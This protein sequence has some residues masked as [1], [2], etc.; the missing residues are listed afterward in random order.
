MST[1]LYG[2]S[3]DDVFLRNYPSL[4][5]PRIRHSSRHCVTYSPIIEQWSV[6]SC[7]QGKI[8]VRRV[9]T[10]G[11]L[12][13]LVPVFREL[14]IALGKRRAKALISELAWS[15]LNTSG[16]SSLIESKQKGH[17]LNY[18]QRQSRCALARFVQKAKK[19]SETLESIVI[20]GKM[21]IGQTYLFD[22]FI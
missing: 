3:S 9:V 15:S 22:L 5:L 8:R 10:C 13:S 4:Q 11:L 20:K 6:R 1:K 18:I 7:D 16:T 19:W 17:H 14:Y 21:F 2:T 12:P